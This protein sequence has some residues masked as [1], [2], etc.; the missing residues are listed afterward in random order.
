MDHYFDVITE[1]VVASRGL[2]RPCGG[3]LRVRF[4][5]GMNT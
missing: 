1:V 2:T 4:R 3:L 5:I